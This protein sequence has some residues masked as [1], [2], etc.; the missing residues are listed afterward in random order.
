MIQTSVAGIVVL[1]YYLENRAKLKYIIQ[2]NQIQKIVN[3]EGYGDN[4]GS[5]GYGKKKAQKFNDLGD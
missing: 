1:S 5:F 4:Y 2:Q 3:I